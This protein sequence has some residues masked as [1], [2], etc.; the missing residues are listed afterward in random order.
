MVKYRTNITTVTPIII[1]D[2]TS[3]TSFN[4]FFAT[5][6]T[7]A[8]FI[9]LGTRKAWRWLLVI[10]YL[11]LENHRVNEQKHN[12]MLVYDDLAAWSYVRNSSITQDGRYAS[13]I[14]TLNFSRIR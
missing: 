2:K 5:H 3:I 11:A 7:I 1:R 4:Y 6:P 8:A 13:N 12:P 14:L 9:V 10:F